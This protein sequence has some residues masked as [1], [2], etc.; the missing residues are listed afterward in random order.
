MEIVFAKTRVVYPSYTDYWRLV[1]LCKFPTCFADNIDFQSDKTFILS[2]LNGEYMPHRDFHRGKP[3]NA[4]V[5]SWCLERPSGTNGLANFRRGQKKLLDEGYF[6]E[7]WL[8]DRFLVEQC[9]DSRVKFVILGSH[10]GLGTLERERPKFDV[11]HLSYETY[12]RGR[13]YA[14]LDKHNISIGKNAW[15][16]DRHARLM[17]TRFMLNVHQDDYGLIEPLRFTLGAAYGLPIITERCYDA[18]P[19]TRGEEDNNVIQ[20]DYSDLA[21]EVVKRKRQDYRW[22]QA[23]GWRCHRLMVDELRFDKMV[24]LAAQGIPMPSTLEIV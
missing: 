19:Y 14:L 20:A 16:D 12:R 3:N 9:E 5:V 1:E 7:I 23:M 17:V 10:V 22:L 24:R 15:G 21:A 13:L 2:P 11:I 18:Y 6:D 4:K 8:S